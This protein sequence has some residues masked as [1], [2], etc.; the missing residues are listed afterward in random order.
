MEMFESYFYH[1]SSYFPIL[2]LELQLLILKK[3]ALPIPSSLFQY[4]LLPLFCSHFLI[5]KTSLLILA[6][7]PAVSALTST[8]GWKMGMLNCR[9]RGKYTNSEKWSLWRLNLT[10]LIASPIPLT[11][12]PLFS[13]YQYQPMACDKLSGNVQFNIWYIFPHL[14]GQSRAHRIIWK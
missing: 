7:H 1:H 3:K 9:A 5:R 8:W 4:L 11:S 6:N 10:F 12:V 13:F 14:V 2:Q